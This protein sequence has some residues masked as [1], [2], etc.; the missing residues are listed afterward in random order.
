MPRS[1]F[2]SVRATVWQAKGATDTLNSLLFE[3]HVEVFCAI[4]VAVGEV[5][6]SPLSLHAVHVDYVARPQAGTGPTRR[7]IEVQRLFAIL[8][9]IP[10]A[11]KRADVYSREASIRGNTVHVHMYM[12]ICKVHATGKGILTE[13]SLSHTLSHTIHSHP[14]SS[15]LLHTLTPLHPSSSTQVDLMKQ[16]HKY[17]HIITYSHPQ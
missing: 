17:L 15:S 9:L 11:F 1:K 8:P 4:G 2:T 10:P 12:Y 16:C 7:L 3:G 5:Q 6:L 13:Y 14:H